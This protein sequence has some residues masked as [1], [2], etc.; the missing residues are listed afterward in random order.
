[1]NISLYNHL[2]TQNNKLAKALKMRKPPGTLSLKKFGL[3]NL[4]VKKVWTQ[5]NCILA[6]HFLKNT[7]S[8][9]TLL[10][11]ILLENSLSE[12]KL[13]ENTLSENTLLEN[14]LSE[15]TLQ[16]IHFR[17]Y[18]SENTLLKNTISENTLLENTLS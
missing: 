5:N 4:W 13:S 9:N 12:N 17:K 10:E 1:M 14:T 2:L 8:E 6:V 15:N 11:N 7:L 3:G 16:K 18:T